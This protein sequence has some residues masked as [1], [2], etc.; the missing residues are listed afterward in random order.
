VITEVT[1]T[2]DLSRIIAALNLNFGVV[3]VAELEGRAT[4]RPSLPKVPGTFLEK[5]VW[6]DCLCL[7]RALPWWSLLKSISTRHNSKKLVTNSSKKI[8]WFRG[9]LRYVACGKAKLSAQL[10]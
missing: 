8:G 1:P 9:V 6:R 4:A 7:L 5:L 2:Y 3:I 10:A